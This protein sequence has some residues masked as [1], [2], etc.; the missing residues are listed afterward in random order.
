[1]A[2]PSPPASRPS[3]GRIALLAGLAVLVLAVVAVVVVVRWNAAYTPV[4][5]TGP[6]PTGTGEPLPA[7]GVTV[8]A[9]GDI[10]CDPDGA[11][12]DDGDGSG[13]DECR[14]R[15]V[16]ELVTAA[17]PAAF[18]ALGDVQYDRGG[19]EAFRAGYDRAFGALLPVTH[20]VPG[21]HEYQTPGAA[22]YYDYFGPRAGPRG[23]GW[24][25]YDL[26]G[27]H[28][29]ALNSNCHD[30]DCSADGDQVR[31]LRSDLA[32]HPATC[33]LAYWHQPRWSS[34][35]HGDNTS[36]GALTAAL[37]D[38]GVDVLLTG[39]DHDYERFRPQD[40]S[41]AAA[42]DGVREFV[43]G[44]G[45][46]NLRKVSHSDGTRAIDNEHF[47]ALL[48]TLTPAAYRWQFRAVGGTVVDRGDASCH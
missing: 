31:W 38:A 14:Y 8:A 43:V 37:V 16:G 2:E 1:M 13:P 28:F 21:N 26:A 25:S 27:W 9:V 44:T 39:H 48:L 33:T 4:P 6:L 3:S 41:G 40:A 5:S 10:A 17:R 30:V 12:D 15:P 29:V 20:P 36:V 22:G 46:R 32:A 23:T 11:P 7:D 42:D 19:L 24:Y 18:L 47:G 45:G 35:V 34:G